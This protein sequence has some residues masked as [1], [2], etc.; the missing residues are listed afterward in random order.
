MQEY[1]G[2]SVPYIYMNDD[3]EEENVLE[4]E[5]NEENEDETMQVGK[6]CTCI[7]FQ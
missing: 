3:D 2:Q 5:S 4:D 6:I 7:H 1:S